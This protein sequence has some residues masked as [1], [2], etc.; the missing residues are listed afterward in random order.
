MTLTEHTCLLAGEHLGQQVEQ[1]LRAAVV[2]LLAGILL[3]LD[4]LAEELHL[5]PHIILQRPADEVLH[6]GHPHLAVRHI[7]HHRLEE[8]NDIRTE[9]EVLIDTALREAGKVRIL[10]HQHSCQCACLLALHQA[11][12]SR[13]VL[14]VGFQGLGKVVAIRTIHGHLRPD[15]TLGDGAHADA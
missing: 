9:G 2:S 15:F 6:L 4:G 11:T 13:E 5:A 14:D 12:G 3:L 10:L 8:G 7:Q 1:V